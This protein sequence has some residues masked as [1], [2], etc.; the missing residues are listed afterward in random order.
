MKKGDD[1]MKTIAPVPARMLLDTSNWARQREQLA[2]GEDK[3]LKKACAE[4]ES[5][6]INQ[7]LKT[8]RRSIPESELF[9]GGLQKDI[10][11][12]LFDEQVARKIAH[13][14]GIG[15]GEELYHALSRKLKPDSSAESGDSESTSQSPTGMRRIAVE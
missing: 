15:I 7:L 14:K 4:F 11:T 3:A 2:T 5:L 6:F 1:K 8:M 10:Y 12:S 9:E 13:G